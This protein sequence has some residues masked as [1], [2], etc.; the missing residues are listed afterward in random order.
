MSLN[1]STTLEEDQL[2]SHPFWPKKD[3]DFK[4][5]SNSLNLS[6]SSWTEEII[7]NALDN[8]QNGDEEEDTRP[9]VHQ[10][11]DKS[12]GESSNEG[13]SFF[14]LTKTS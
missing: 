9:D 10:S 1:S 8:W 5:K 7:H 13:T 14:S 4:S 6:G 12:H 3:D 2:A 11:H